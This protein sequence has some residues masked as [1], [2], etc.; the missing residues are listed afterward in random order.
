VAISRIQKLYAIEKHTKLLPANE[1]QRIREIESVPILDKF[2]IWLD[3]SAQTLPA[4]SYLGIAVSY[5][6]NYWQAL[7]RYVGNGE[8]SIDN[9][10]TERDI[11]PFTRVEKTGCLHHQ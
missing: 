7:T 5:T 6:L 1:R 11:R 9:N 2:K 4:K 10:V 3:E 8:L